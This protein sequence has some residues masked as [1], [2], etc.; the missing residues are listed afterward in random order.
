MPVAKGIRHHF[1]TS[2]QSLGF[3]P[4]TSRSKAWRATNWA[5][6]IIKLNRRGLIFITFAH[7]LFA[8]LPAVTKLWPRLCFYSCLWFCPQGGLPQCMLG[9]QPPP[10]K[11]TP[12][13][14]DPPPAYGQWAAGTHPTGMHSCNGHH[15]A[16]LAN[17]FNLQLTSCDRTKDNFRCH[18]VWITPYSSWRIPSLIPSAR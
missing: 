11:Q 13:R 16:G 6:I 17:P 3:E 1:T 4:M 7:I 2:T 12:P 5:N 10:P 8:F 14:A 15:S 9:Y 18:S